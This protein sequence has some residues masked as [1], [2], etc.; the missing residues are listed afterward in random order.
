M[1]AGPGEV[2]RML[3]GGCGGF[4]DTLRPPV[5]EPRGSPRAQLAPAPEQR[6]GGPRRDIMR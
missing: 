1:R 6:S 2:T 4:E 3:A 5:Q